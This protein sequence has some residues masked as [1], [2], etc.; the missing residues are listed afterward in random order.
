[1]KEVEQMLG[2]PFF[3]QGVVVK[4]EGRGR[5]LGFATANLKL[6]VKMVVPYGVY[7]SR[8]RVGS[9]PWRASI[10]NVGLRPTFTGAVA[11]DKNEIPALIE[12]HLLDQNIDLYG[13]TLEVR[14]LERIR[15]EKK[16]ENFEA[17]VRQI[18]DDISFARKILNAHES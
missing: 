5:K 1:M 17:L 16:F 2:E 12:T 15:A 14:L 3:Y 11:G 6:D 4:G 8:S 9:G 13:Q 7:A 18:H 10:T